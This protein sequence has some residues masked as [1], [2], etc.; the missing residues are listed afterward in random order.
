MIKTYFLFIISLLF[1]FDLYCQTNSSYFIDTTI[2]DKIDENIKFTNI[3]V[4]STMNFTTTLNDSSD[5]KNLY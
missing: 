4:E 1:Y 5:V 3:P 2:K